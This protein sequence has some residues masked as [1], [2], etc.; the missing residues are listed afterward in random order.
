MPNHA[1]RKLERSQQLYLAHQ[2]IIDPWL[3]RQ[4]GPVDADG[5]TGTVADFPD[6]RKRLEFQARSAQ[7]T[8]ADRNLW[9]CALQLRSSGIRV[10]PL[11][12]LPALVAINNAPVI[13]PRRRVLTEREAWRLQA[14]PVPS[15]SHQVTVDMLDPTPDA[16]VVTL[17]RPAAGQRPADTEPVTLVG[18]D[19]DAA[20]TAIRTIVDVWATHGGAHPDT[21]RAAADAETAG[22]G[23]TAGELLVAAGSYSETDPRLNRPGV[24][25]ARLLWDTYDL[26]ASAGS[27]VVDPALAAVDWRVMVRMQAAVGR[28]AGQET[29]EQARRFGASRLPLALPRVDT[30]GGWHTYATQTAAGVAAGW[31]V[32]WAVPLCRSRLLS[33]VGDAPGQRPLADVADLEVALVDTG[34]AVLDPDGPDGPG[35]RRTDGP[36]GPDGLG[37]LTWVAD[38]PEQAAEATLLTSGAMAPAPRWVAEVDDATVAASVT[39]ADDTLETVIADAGGIDWDEWGTDWDI[40]QLC[41]DLRVID[42]HVLAVAGVPHFDLMVALASYERFRQVVSLIEFEYGHYSDEAATLLARWDPGLCH[43]NAGEAV[44]DIGWGYAL[45]AAHLARQCQQDEPGD[46]ADVV[47][48]RAA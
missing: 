18:V 44:L 37:H 24:A 20:D 47:T 34:L 21:V 28:A 25:H 40:E 48:L 36:H 22:C 8:A 10:K 3:A 11:T 43:I 4:R 7:P 39:L 31:P 29:T 41:A 27:E 45:G 6:S 1:R 19:V 14:L 46:G 30:D 26:L 12:Y 13:G 15:W 38:H 35:G 42:A 9:Q 2:N 33:T 32:E 5:T 23:L 17:E 16:D